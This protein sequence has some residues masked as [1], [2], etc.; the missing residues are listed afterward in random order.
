MGSMKSLV[1]HLLLL[2]LCAMR[3]TSLPTELTTTQQTEE[4]LIPQTT[5]EAAA[6]EVMLATVGIVGDGG[7]AVQA[8][9][10][11]TL[12]PFLPTD[13]LPPSKVKCVKVGGF[14]HLADVCCTKRCLT[15]ARRCVT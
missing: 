3:A 13:E 8:V 5:V 7:D 12:M 2:S 14:C 9:V 6:N 4:P 11:S 10:T 15:F 1:L